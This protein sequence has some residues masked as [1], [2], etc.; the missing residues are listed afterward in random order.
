MHYQTRVPKFGR[1]ISYHFPSCD[2][3]VCGASHQ[4]WRL[5]LEQGR[6][7]APLE[8]TLPEINSISINPAHQLFGFGGSNGKVEFWHPN[9]KKRIGILDVSESIVKSMDSS[10]LEELPQITSLKFGSDGLSVMAGTSTGQVVLY[11]L[12]RPTPL[13]IKDHQYGFPIKSLTFHASGKI[14]S[15]DTKIVKIWDQ[16]TGNVFTN[17]EA[18][19][20]INDTCVFGGD[21]GLVMLAGE[22]AQIQSYYVPALGPAPKWCPFLDNLTEELEE[23][24]NTAI[25][26]DYKF[27]T[28]KELSNL[29][30]D[31]LM[32]TNVLK[33]YMHGFFIDLRLYEKAKAISNPFEYDD[34]KKRMVQKRIE[35]KR[36]SRISAIKKLPKV[37]RNI[38]ADLLID[39]DDDETTEMPTKSK[40]KQESDNIMK[41]SRFTSLFEDEDFQIDETSH[42]YKLH[43][44]SQDG[45]NA[46]ANDQDTLDQESNLLQT[47]ETRIQQESAKPR[48]EITGVHTGNMSITFNP[49]DKKKSRVGKNDD[50]EKPQR[51]SAGKSKF[52]PRR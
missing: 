10:L 3:L 41:D 43:H 50:G 30:L 36:A 1:D 4:V 34:Y 24:P 16:H 6:F 20:D 33:A 25:Y 19:N 11:D 22:G 29:G 42:E 45:F 52:K 38:A 18:P 32:G 9:E 35:E 47:F 17:I 46:M 14:L 40:K 21:T 26:D 13:I 51:R 27:V 12:R 23:N 44:P 28:R 7:M 31:H 49:S 5:N 15:S 48:E 8:T 39:T 2:V 37:N